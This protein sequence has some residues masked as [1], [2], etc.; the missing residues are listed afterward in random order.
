MAKPGPAEFLKFLST[1]KSGD[2]V[3]E[4]EILAAVPSWKSSTLDTYRKKNKLTT[5]LTVTGKGTYRA[6]Q[7]GANVTEA[8]INAALS[9]VSPS[10]VTVARNDRLKGCVGEYVLVRAIGSGAVG[11]VWS[12]TDASTGGRVAVKICNPRPDLLELAVHGN[13]KDRFRR[14]ARL[15]PKLKHD[16]II[17]YIDYGD[18]LTTSFLVMELAQSS[19]RDQIAAKGP[20][21]VAQAAAVALR[22]AD[23]L[24]WVHQQSCVHRDIKPPNILL[25]PRGHVIAD[26]GIVRWGDLSRAFTDAGTITR[27]AVQLGSMHYMAPEQS[28][29]P[30]EASAA[31]DI[32]ALGVTIIEMLTGSAPSPQRVA[33]RQIQP[34]STNKSLN[35]L[36]ERMTEYDASTRPTVNEVE[37][38]LKDIARK[39]AK[40]AG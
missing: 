30:H 6:V 22:V 3:T 24:R 9:Q 1:L 4:D 27:T 37:A 32:Y 2:S 11:H 14:E 40:A 13:V 26:L 17:E 28:D 5:F 18:H 35:Q 12:A 20:L 19:L 29:A 16:T 8:E 38:V 33:A 21:A 39:S 10:A 23:G 7:D 31:S 15:G 36:I 34:P 25:T